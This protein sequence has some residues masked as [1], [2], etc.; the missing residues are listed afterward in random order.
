MNLFKDYTDSYNTSILELISWKATL[1]RTFLGELRQYIRNF[2]IHKYKTLSKLKNTRSGTAV[3]CSLGPSLYENKTLTRELLIKASAKKSLFV[4]NHFMWT[5]FSDIMPTYQFISDNNFFYDEKNYKYVTKVESI[6]EI[7]VLTRM[8][9]SYE[10]KNNTVIYFSGL[11]LS[12]IIKGIN[13]KIVVGFADIT[14]LYSLSVAFYMGYSKVIVCGFDNNRFMHINS[15]SPGEIY[16]KGMHSYNSGEVEKW[17]TRDSMI[18]IL[19]SHLVILKSLLLFKNKKIFI[20]GESSL[21]DV[22]PKIDVKT[23]LSL[24]E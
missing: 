9:N 21:I 24:L 2:S 15:V 5:E 19:S 6:P 4:I 18:K 12:T 14:V 10:F 16:F 1:V 22:F 17:G 13:P 23:A 20:I 3:I 8:A 11:N 7:T